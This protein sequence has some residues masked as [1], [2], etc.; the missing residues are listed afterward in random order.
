MDNSIA[1]KLY[2]QLQQKVET[3]Q[4]LNK[5]VEGYI[6]QQIK[7]LEEV[8]DN[9]VKNA[10]EKNSDL[11]NNL[12]FSEIRIKQLQAI[13][14]LCKKIGIPTEKYENRIR[15]IRVYHLGADFVKERYK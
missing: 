6:K 11:V 2:L 7:L 14:S 15:E 9:F 3:A 12:G 4:K 1:Q 10:L 8:H 5:P 13:I